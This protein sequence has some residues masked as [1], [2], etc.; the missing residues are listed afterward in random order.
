VIVW[1]ALIGLWALAAVK[2]L[3]LPGDGHT[4]TEPSDELAE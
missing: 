4:P 3:Q 1:L 2:V